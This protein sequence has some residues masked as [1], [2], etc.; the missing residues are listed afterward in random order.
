MYINFSLSSYSQ[1]HLAKRQYF[2]DMK[3]LAK[4]GITLKENP[5]DTI[6]EAPQKH[7]YQ[8]EVLQPNTEKN[9]S[10]KKS[11]EANLE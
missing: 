3:F 1:R 4:Y 7:F 6:T 9:Y 10:P 8:T 5:L 2:E 11:L